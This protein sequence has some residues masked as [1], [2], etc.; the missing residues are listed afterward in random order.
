MIIG[1]DLGTSVVKAAAFSGNG[2]ILTHQGRR[3]KL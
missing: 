2:E 1:I 3:V